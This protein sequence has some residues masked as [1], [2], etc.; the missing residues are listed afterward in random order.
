MAIRLRIQH[1]EL[2]AI[3]VLAFLIIGPEV[4]Y[5]YYLVN[6]VLIVLV[7][8]AGHEEAVMASGLLRWF[9][10]VALLLSLVP[11]G[12]LYDESGM[13]VTVQLAGPSWLLVFVLALWRSMALGLRELSSERRGE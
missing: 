11:F 10:L 5:G 2:S 6:S 12:W 4:S 7:L 1:F 8:M 9:V 3:V 13:S